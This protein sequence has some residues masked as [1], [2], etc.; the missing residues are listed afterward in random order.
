MI[1]NDRSPCS[2]FANLPFQSCL[3]D[4]STVLSKWMEYHHLGIFQSPQNEYFTKEIHYFSYHPN[5]LLSLISFSILAVCVYFYHPCLLGLGIFF[6]TPFFFTLQ[7]QV[8]PKILLNLSL[9]C[10]WESI[11]PLCVL[12][13]WLSFGLYLG[14][15]IRLLLDYCHS[16]LITFPGIVVGNDDN[17]DDC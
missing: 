4:L 2:Y 11:P 7:V 5:N 9:E 1:E 8:V 10:L 3:R 17:N 6:L 12:S 15:N 16:F 14:I 13:K